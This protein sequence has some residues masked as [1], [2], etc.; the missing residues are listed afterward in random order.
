MLSLALRAIRKR[1]GLTAR[2]VAGRLS[3]LQRTYELFEAGSGQLSVVKIFAFAQ[4]TDS[5]PFAILA[6][7]EL[8]MPQFAAD[9]ADNKLCQILAYALQD[10]HA[11]L[12]E[13]VAELEAATLIAA[14]SST[15]RALAS[16]VRTRRMQADEWMRRRQVKRDHEGGGEDG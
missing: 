14:F 3:M 15:M 12:G 4:A 2:Q 11:D 8:G 5:D 6:A 9:C 16:D 7:V 1:R 13:Q 10:L